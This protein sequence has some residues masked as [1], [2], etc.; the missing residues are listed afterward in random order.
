MKRL[1]TAGAAGILLA[2]A[3]CGSTTGPPDRRHCCA[4]SSKY[5]TTA[6]ATSTSGD[7][8]PPP[9]GARISLPDENTG[10]ITPSPGTGSAA[11][12]P[13]MFVSQA[14][15]YKG[16]EFKALGDIPATGQAICAAFR[17]GVSGQTVVGD[18]EGGTYSRVD[19][20]YFVTLSVHWLCPD[21]MTSLPGR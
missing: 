10:N 2:V 19:A 7:Y 8:A 20:L 18:L 13:D 4:I 17:R 6:P 21:Q 1:A 12:Q 5:T 14:D 16:G 3:A 9:P 15:A 11:P